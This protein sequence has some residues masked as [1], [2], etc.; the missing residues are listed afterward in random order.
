MNTK[1]LRN[2]LFYSISIV[3]II[4]FFLL[5]ATTVLTPQAEAESITDL[6]IDDFSDDNQNAYR[7]TNI[8][9]FVNAQTGAFMRSASEDNKLDILYNAIGI[10]ESDLSG[11][12][13]SDLLTAESITVSRTLIT[14]KEDGTVTT[15][16]AD[17]ITE[18]EFDDIVNDKGNDGYMSG[19]IV[20]VQNSDYNH[21]SST[22]GS[23]L[24]YGFECAFTMTWIKDPTYRM[25]DKFTFCASN[26]AY[27][28]NDCNGY[29]TAKN[30]M[31]I[32]NGITQMYGPYKTDITDKS[33]YSN[34]WSVF[35][36][37]LPSNVTSSTTIA[38]YSNLGVSVRARLYSLNNFNIRMNYA[39]K[40]II[41]GAL[42]VSISTSGPS[43]SFSGTSHREY[44]TSNMYVEIEK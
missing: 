18:E 38:K 12:N 32:Y 42:G 31:I 4:L 2:S 7:Y 44:Q 20:V 3:L 15:R 23:F 13:P 9:N 34:G 39:H 10:S 22:S 33:Y 6:I 37:D 36:V 43:I 11:I 24:A 25:T 21:L 27:M 8:E 26:G 29:L 30:A 41:P 19:K 16:A 5:V 14:T 28:L 17:K 35:N 1:F 40:Q